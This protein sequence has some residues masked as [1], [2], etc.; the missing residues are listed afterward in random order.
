[1]PSLA[2]ASAV[3]PASQGL[4]LGAAGALLDQPA[5]AGTAVALTPHSNGVQLLV[6]SVLGPARARQLAGLRAKPFTPH[7]LGSVPANAMAYLGL[8]LLERAGARLLEAGLA[9]GG[10]RRQITGLLQRAQ[11]DL[12]RRTGVNLRRDILPLLQ[13]EV[14]LWLSP[15]VPA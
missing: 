6:H 12:Q 15:A 7:L 5:L 9:G 4:P 3:R 13:G 1:M 14:A 2:R 11:R 10:A 8:P